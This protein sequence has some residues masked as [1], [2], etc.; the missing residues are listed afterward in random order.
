MNKLKFSDLDIKDYTGGQFKHLNE[1]ELMILN[2]A[3]SMLDY[4]NFKNA[5]YFFYRSK[6]TAIYYLLR[7]D[8][9]NDIMLRNINKVNEIKMWDS[10]KQ[11][12]A[13]THIYMKLEKGYSHNEAFRRAS[14]IIDF[15][16]ESNFNYCLDYFPME[17]IDSV[18]RMLPKMLG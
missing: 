12:V 13:V 18:C 8:L 2:L 4:E 5:G 10:F 15:N 14:H 17:F 7:C 9:E 3:S 16:S 1:Y 11:D 6:D